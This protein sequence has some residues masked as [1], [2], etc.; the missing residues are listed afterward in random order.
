MQR[1]AEDGWVIASHSG[2][3]DLRVIGL[4]L[5]LALQ[6]RGRP[7]TRPLAD[8][9]LRDN[10]DERLRPRLVQQLLQQEPLLLVLDDFEQNLSTGGE[11]FLDPDTASALELLLASAERGALL[12]TCRHPLP[13]AMEGLLEVPVGPLS[14]AETRKLVQ[15]LPGLCQ[16]P[17]AELAAAL[18]T[19]GGHPRLLEFLDGLLRQG[20]GRLPAVSQ[21][22]R[23]ALAAA[24]LAAP[25]AP[26]RL[27]EGL[28]QALILG[29]RDVLLAELLAIARQRGDDAVLLQLAVSNLPVAPVGLARM[30][31]GVVEASAVEPAL[32]R[33]AALSLVVRGE[34]GQAWMH[35]WSAEGLAALVEAAGHGE[36]HRR[37]GDY[38]RWRIE[39]E[40]HA[41][42]DGLEAVRNYLR[43]GHFDAAAEVAQGCLAALARFGQTVAVATLA[44]EVLERL[45]SEHSGFAG[46]ADAEA[47]AHWALGQGKRAFARFQE[48]LERRERLAKAEPDR[49]DY[50]RDLSVSYERM[51]DLYV[52]L[53]Q[54]EAARQAYQGS[55]EIRE[56]LAKAEPDR[57]DYQRDLSVSYNKM[58]DLYRALGQGE[59]ARQAY[60][61]SLEIAERLAKAE[62]DRADAELD[63]VISL[64]KIGTVAEPVERPPLERALAI[65]LRLDQQGRL[66][67]ADQPKIGA[68]R[69]MLG[70]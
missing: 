33:L 27:D 1:L 31:A 42:E 20:E 6:Q 64:V 32:A 11:T 41:L 57:A 35:R 70:G 40:S 53:G 39:N 22:L 51:G 60:Q 19:I 38:R 58:G 21:R 62:P 50:Q 10:L 49:A 12:L 36:R 34:E 28:Q 65:L 15:R 8:L 61:G 26:A 4:E 13:Q 69:Q 44:A 17:D 68:L 45:P 56:R 48:L 55:L 46:L 5:G 29:A 54:G 9:L 18:R 37:A 43:G 14:G 3:F 67:P 47:Q 2:R 25:A 59:A 52:A 24:G 66:A 16:R 63:L 7:S 30:L 23:Q